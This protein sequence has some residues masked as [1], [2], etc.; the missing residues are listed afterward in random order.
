MSTLVEPSAKRTIPKGSGL[1]S[2]LIVGTFTAVLC[3]LM[4]ALNKSASCQLVP[5]VIF[6][7]DDGEALKRGQMLFNDNPAI[8]LNILNK[9]IESV[10]DTS[11]I[12]SLLFQRAYTFQQLGEH[13]AG[14]NDFMR[15]D[16]LIAA[17]GFKYPVPPLDFSDIYVE[18]ESKLYKNFVSAETFPL[19]P[20]VPHIFE[21]MESHGKTPA[22]KSATNFSALYSYHLQ[23]MIFNIT[24]MDPGIKNGAVTRRSAADYARV[25]LS[26]QADAIGSDE[27][28]G[29][30]STTYDL[31]NQSNLKNTL[32]VF[33]RS[34]QASLEKD[35][36]HLKQT[37]SNF[38]KDLIWSMNSL[39]KQPSDTS[40]RPGVFK[41]KS[42]LINLLSKQMLLTDSLLPLSA[43]LELT[44]QMNS[45]SDFLLAIRMRYSPRSTGDR[46]IYELE[47][48]IEFHKSIRNILVAILSGSVLACIALYVAKKRAQMKRRRLLLE[49]LKEMDTTLSH[50][51]EGVK[52]L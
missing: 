37:A 39:T 41:S 22:K 44:G 2:K 26:G 20:K 19:S 12:V 51:I 15:A 29:S 50:I 31:I 40:T 27:V 7:A 24:L 25:I 14:L 36:I 9:R 49:V 33:I 1:S 21:N 52:R 38:F 5:S 35:D 34:S 42:P 28:W 4:L 8:R 23:S 11:A 6:D 13:D 10:T 45:Y 43:Q 32:A 16:Q 18:L 46:R 48:S 47:E 3:L 17:T 30:D